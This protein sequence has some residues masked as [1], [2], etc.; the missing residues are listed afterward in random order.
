[1]N[2]VDEDIFILELL[3]Y[4]S[5]Y[6]NVF[7][8]FNEISVITNRNWFQFVSISFYT[9]NQKRAGSLESYL[10]RKLHIFWEVWIPLDYK[11]TISKLSRE[12]SDNLFIF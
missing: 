12:I 4:F 8:S 1:M 6:G 5:A 9:A 7:N 10:N 11:V 3:V 2:Y